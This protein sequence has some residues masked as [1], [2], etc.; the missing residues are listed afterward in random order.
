MAWR[1]NGGGLG[2]LSRALWAVSSW[3]KW[4]RKMDNLQ[5]SFLSFISNIQHL[6]YAMD[7][8]Y[9]MVRLGSQYHRIPNA[10][11]IDLYNTL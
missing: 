1:K 11:F 7:N 8:S 6:N 4:L 2:Y 5:H 10:W 9:I 3:K